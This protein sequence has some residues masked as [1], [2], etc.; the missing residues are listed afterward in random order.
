MASLGCERRPNIQGNGEQ[1]LQGAWKE[2]ALADSAA[3]LTYTMYQFKFTCDSF[4]VQ[5]TTHAKVNYYEE[6]CFNG[7]LWKEYAKGV[8]SVRKDSLFLDGLYTKSNYKQ[9]VSGCY[10]SGRFLKSFIVERSKPD[11]LLLKNT[12]DQR[13]SRLALIQKIICI[14][15]AL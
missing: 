9:K 10:Q 15:K 4:Y 12:I 7:G 1:F 5:L 3:L 11:T 6:S 2:E 13:Q 8:Y 14:P